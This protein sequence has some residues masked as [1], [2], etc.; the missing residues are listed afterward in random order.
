MARSLMIRHSNNCIYLRS[1]ASEIRE[2]VK[3]F[4]DKRNNVLKLIV[5]ECDGDLIGELIELDQ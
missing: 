4:V 1:P 5:I 2:V 3:D